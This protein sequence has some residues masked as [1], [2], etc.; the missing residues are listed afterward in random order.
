MVS[1]DSSHQVRTKCPDTWRYCATIHS[2]GSGWVPRRD[3]QQ[4]SGFRWMSYF[5][6]GSQFT[7]WPW[8]NNLGK[9][10]TSIKSPRAMSLASSDLQCGRYVYEYARKTP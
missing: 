9:L 8:K 3:S 10:R 6:S 2:S 7:T 5:E 4:A 1:P